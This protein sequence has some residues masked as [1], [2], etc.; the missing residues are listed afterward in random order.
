MFQCISWCSKI[1][2]LSNNRK[3]DS[4][5]EIFLFKISNL[6]LWNS[7]LELTKF[8]NKYEFPLSN[9]DNLKYSQIK[10]SIFIE[11]IDEYAQSIHVPEIQKLIKFIKLLIIYCPDQRIDQNSLSFLLSRYEVLNEK[12]IE[13]IYDLGNNKELSYEIIIEIIRIKYFNFIQT[14]N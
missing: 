6:F 11:K 9:F 1:V 8:F 12:I 14:M 4:Q 3:G 5:W 13:E 7:I 10:Y 2:F